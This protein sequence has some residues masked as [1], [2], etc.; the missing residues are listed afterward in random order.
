MTG[1]K[2]LLMRRAS[3]ALRA[4]LLLAAP[5]SVV[6]LLARPAWDTARSAVLDL[7]SSDA[8]VSL[9]AAVS[10]VA[11]LGSVVAGGWLLASL[12]TCTVTALRQ[13]DERR[14]PPGGGGLLPALQ[15]L[16]L[17]MLVASALG[18]AVGA[19]AAVAE[20]RPNDPGP[21]P[22]AGLSPP[23]RPLGELQP[24]EDGVRYRVRSGDC[25]WTIAARTLPPGAT[26]AAVDRRWRALYRANR[27]RVG[28]DPDLIRPGL[29]LHLSP[30]TPLRSP[31][32]RTPEA[33]P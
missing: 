24:R 16:I 33:R 19:S 31:P 20:P 7:E 10:L 25:L 26:P 30:G 11:L 28:P 18:T 5:A 22:I 3:V 12:T 27:A 15:P 1:T 23:E 4:L 13:A 21:S 9:P 17:R 29:V 14:P 2:G 8:A 32:T 6:V